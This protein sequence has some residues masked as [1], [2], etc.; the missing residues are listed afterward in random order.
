[1]PVADLQAPRARLLAGPGGAIILTARGRRAARQ[2]HRHG[3]RLHQPGARARPARPARLRA[4]AASPGRATARAAASTGRRPT[5][6]PATAGS[7]TRPRGRTSPR[8]GASTPTTCPGPGVSAYELLD[9]LGTA[10]RA[11]GA[12][13][14]RLQPGRLAPR[15]PAG[16]ERRLRALDLLVVADFVLS[17]T[18][19][20]ADVVLPTA[21]WAEEDGTMTNLEGRVLRRRALRPPPPGV[22]TDLADPG[23]AGRTGWAGRRVRRSRPARADF[24]ELRR[25]SAGGPADYAGIDLGAHRRRGRRVLALPRRRSTRARRGCSPTG[26]PPPDGRARFVPVEHR[27]AAEEPDADVPV[28]PDHRPGAGP[29][30]VR[31]ADPA[32]RAA[33]P[34]RARAFVELHPDPAAGSASRTA[35]RYGW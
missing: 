33:A 15:A 32:G 6:C 21:Q 34:G 2:G 23:R 35:T 25:A 20:L 19:A 31:R 10:G 11:A 4:T 18:A 12:A 8:C 27:P 16:V 13:G 3:H 7:T 1:M 30:P 26:S 14:L 17:E 28:L 5:S 24:D 22:R 9:P 29:V